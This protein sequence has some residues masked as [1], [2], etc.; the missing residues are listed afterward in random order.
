MDTATL[1]IVDR[2]LA[3][4][5]VRETARA[6]GRPP[7]SIAAA[8]QRVEE[9]LAT[10]LLHASG[11]RLMRTLDGERL[12]PGFSEMARQCRAIFG[13][14][15]ADPVPAVSLAL[16]ERFLV[17]A[18]KGSIR[19]AAR[20]AGL[21]QPQLTRQL[22]QA[23]AKIGRPLLDRRH[24][25]AIPTPAGLEVIAAARRIEDVWREMAARSG[26]RFRRNVTTVRVGSVFPLGA[27]SSIA[28]LLAR[29]S[30]RWRLRHP[31]LPLFVTSM[32]AEELLNGVRR[33]LFD[34]VLL[35]LDELPADLDGVELTRSPLVL[36]A[37]TET[38]ERAGGT[39]ANLLLTS[40]MAVPSPR[41][42]LRQIIDRLLASDGFPELAPRLDL[43]EVDSIPVILRLVE[44]HG[45]ISILPGSSL[46]GHGHRL[47]AL[48]L[49]ETAILPLYAAW[50]K[51]RGDPALVA[52]VLS[53]V[54]T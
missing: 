44:D 29:L 36:V 41:S 49:P 32:I 30:A 43:M 52:E 26:E 2:L 23:E 39:L 40:P 11:G 22:A 37:S 42:G 12:M 20:E 10:P 24:G 28:G 45:F 19:G 51:G 15:D 50:P 18:R 48:A 27:E 38:A 46:T 25:G 1:V 17:V 31:R 16:L 33:G 3:L 13:A 9:A 47:S 5:S 8:L 4:M 14:G 21:G 6:L 53:L 7:A 35:D 34:V 54:G